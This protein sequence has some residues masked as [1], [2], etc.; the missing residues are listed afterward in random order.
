MAQFTNPKGRAT[1]RLGAG[2]GLVLP[3][4]TR[5][6]YCRQPDRGWRKHPL[7]LRQSLGPALVV[8][9]LFFEGPSLVTALS[10][11]NEEL[12]LSTFCPQVSA[13]NVLFV[14]SLCLTIILDKILVE[15]VFKKCF[16]QD[17][18]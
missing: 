3:Y 10:I 17:F 2:A 15:F 5:F 1:L 16:I 14:F 11:R 8:H 9:A 7:V 13:R 6:I 4:E 12:H 18:M